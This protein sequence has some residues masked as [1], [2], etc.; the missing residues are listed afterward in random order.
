VT[1]TASCANATTN[2]CR[3]SG[4]AGSMH[5]WPGRLTSARITEAPARAHL[6]QTAESA[7]ADAT[8]RGARHRP[9]L[10][11]ARAAI[12][13]AI[14]T[15]IDWLAGQI[16]SPP[17]SVPATTDQIV[18][19]IGQLLSGD[20]QR[21][22]DQCF[23]AAERRAKR[24]ALADHFFCALLAEL[25]HAIQEVGDKFGQLSDEMVSAIIRA[26]IAEGR[27]AIS[28]FLVRLAIQATVAGLRNVISH[29]SLVGQIGNLQRAI[30]ILAI[31]M[32][33]APE[34]HQAVVQYCIDPLGRPIIA[35]EIRERLLQ[36]M[37]RWMTGTS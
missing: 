11:K 12:A 1:H 21:A 16:A 25:A 35:G 9:T 6:R 20:V 4:C 33:P 8:K 3:C 22:L 26:R 37:P 36:S 30:R 5:G 32:C 24:L 31:F 14:T 15:V 7:W 29:L 18:E 10:K 28:D 19:E 23:S 13:G 27:S 17:R 2:Q 34:K